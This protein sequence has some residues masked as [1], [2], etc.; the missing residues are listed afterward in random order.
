MCVLL[1]N[2][3]LKFNWIGWLSCLICQLKKLRVFFVAWLRTERLLPRLIASRGSWSLWRMI[4]NELMNTFCWING[5]VRL[6]LYWPWWLKLIIWYPRKKWHKVW[7]S[8]W[9]M[10][11]KCELMWKWIKP[12]IFLLIIGRLYSY[13]SKY[14]PTRES[15]FLLMQIY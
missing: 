15:I 4:W 12:K 3:T 2:C 1:L 5:P 9:G 6:I 13:K 8:K 14:I 11:V 7:P 10:N